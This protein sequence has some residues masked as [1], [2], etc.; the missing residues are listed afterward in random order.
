MAHHEATHGSP[1]DEYAFT[2]EGSSYE[3]TDANVWV[4]AKFGLWLGVTAIVVHLGIWVMWNTMVGR[5]K[6]TQEQRYPLAVSSDAKLPPEPRLQ[7]F[8]RNE[9]YS[10]RVK[11]Q[12]RL[13]SYGY[14]NKEAGVVHIPIEEAMKLT[15]ERGLPSR[16]EDPTQPAAT[17]GQ[18]A[19]DASSGRVMERRRQ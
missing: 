18:M 12:E 6:E 19:S 15:I 5:A 10:F 16:T 7:Q 2:P 9:A 4:I 3:H 13:H 1:D 11:E 14:I 8:P 17:P